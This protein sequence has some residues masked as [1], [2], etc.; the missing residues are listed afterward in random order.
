MDPIDSG[1]TRLSAAAGDHDL[2]GLEDAVLARVRR[3]ASGDIF[4]G[5]ALPI[6]LA[7]TGAALLVGLAVAQLAYD[8]PAPRSETAVLSDDSGLAPSVALEGGV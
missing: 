3:D 4:R 7:V 2:A 5:R 8:G 6:Q 1:L